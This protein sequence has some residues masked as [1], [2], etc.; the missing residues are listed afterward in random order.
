MSDRVSFNLDEPVFRGSTTKAL[1]KEIAITPRVPKEEVS[2]PEKLPER[3]RDDSGY[4]AVRGDFDPIRPTVNLPEPFFLPKKVDAKDITEIEEIKAQLKKLQKALDVKEEETKKVESTKKKEEPVKPIELLKV[5]YDDTFFGL[6]ILGFVPDPLFYG[7]EGDNNVQVRLASKEWFRDYWEMIANGWPLNGNL[8]LNDWKERSAMEFKE[9]LGIN[10]IE[11]MPDGTK[12]NHIYQACL[13]YPHADRQKDRYKKGDTRLRSDI[14][15]QGSSGNPFLPGNIKQLKDGSTKDVCA[16]KQ[17]DFEFN[18]MIL[19]DF[20]RNW[21]YYNPDNVT[22]ELFGKSGVRK[23]VECSPQ[24]EFENSW[25]PLEYR[26]QVYQAYDMTEF[27]YLNDFEFKTLLYNVAG[28][29]IGD[30]SPRDVDING[31]TFVTINIGNRAYKVYYAQVKMNYPLC[32]E[33]KDEGITLAEWCELDGTD[34]ELLPLFY[35]LLNLEP[36]ANEGLPGIPGILRDYIYERDTRKGKVTRM[37]ADAPLSAFQMMA[38]K[39]YGIDN[40]KNPT[41]SHDECLQVFIDNIYQ[42]CRSIPF[43]DWPRLEDEEPTEKYINVLTKLFEYGGNKGCTVTEAMN[44]AKKAGILSPQAPMTKP[45]TF[46]DPKFVLEAPAIVRNVLEE[47]FL[48]FYRTKVAPF[49]DGAV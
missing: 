47:N 20:L 49:V 46:V 8:G 31:H 12:I 29:V 21:T 9:K 34:D 41:T 16:P 43:A 24:P 38:M 22:I 35:V 48:E 6:P 44:K 42:V 10:V 45:N 30:D 39:K 26:E 27:K 17:F 14:R 3:T 7:L 40:D 1:P 36:P 28:P 25:V 32:S 37:W 15:A 4:G 18:G 2:F 11:E 13:W 33:R 5:Q 19:K 23:T